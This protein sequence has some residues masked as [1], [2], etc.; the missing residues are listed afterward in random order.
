[1]ALEN[2]LPHR[3]ICGFIVAALVLQHAAAQYE[4]PGFDLILL[5]RS[6]GV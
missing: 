6:A 3:T 5:V 1:M 4:D 2:V